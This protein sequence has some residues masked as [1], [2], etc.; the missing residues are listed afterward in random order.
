MMRIWGCYLGND[1]LSGMWPILLSRLLDTMDFVVISW[2][3]YFDTISHESIGQTNNSWHDIHISS[4]LNCRRNMFTWMW[5]FHQQ[6][7]PNL[8]IF[9]S[10]HVPSTLMVSILWE[11]SRSD[12]NHHFVFFLDTYTQFTWALVW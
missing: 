11:Q 12:T 5:S 10:H 8:S 7:S 9:S 4:N 1:Y 6:K 3:I 2:F